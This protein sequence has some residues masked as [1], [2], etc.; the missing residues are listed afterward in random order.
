MTDSDHILFAIGYVKDSPENLCTN[1]T[2]HILD[3]L[4]SKGHGKFVFT[5]AGTVALSGEQPSFGGRFA[6]F[7]S[8]LFFKAKQEDKEN[9]Y[10]LLDKFP[11]VNWSSIRPFKISEGKKTEQYQLGFMK[12]ELSASISY[13][14][15][16]HAMLNML[17]SDEWKHQ[18]PFIK[19]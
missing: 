12:M 16:A 5:G 15:A 18:S 13:A 19:Y 10:A 14:D 7:M 8:K 3:I 6:H 4:K 11:D 1:A 9:Q 2:R 17:K